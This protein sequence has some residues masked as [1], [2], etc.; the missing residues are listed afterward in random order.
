MKHM[1][2]ML[3]I[4]LRRF[5]STSTRTSAHSERLVVDEFIPKCLKFGE[6]R[7]HLSDPCER[8][9]ISFCNLNNLGV[10][11]CESLSLRSIHK[12]LVLLMYMTRALRYVPRELVSHE[13][14]VVLYL[15]QVLNSGEDGSGS[16][17]QPFTKPN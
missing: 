8:W 13:K 17:I 14:I 4:Q 9:E 10:L 15:L 6:I 3:S 11:P 7:T 16:G 2:F 12:S 1:F 5:W